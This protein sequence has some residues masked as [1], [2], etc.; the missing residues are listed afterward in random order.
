MGSAE[1]VS[2]GMEPPAEL[3]LMELFRARERG[4]VAMLLSLAKGEIA[5]TQC[6]PA[7]L[8]KVD[9][10]FDA[11]EAELEVPFISRGRRS[12]VE[13]AA[14]REA[15]RRYLEEAGSYLRELLDG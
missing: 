15:R 5:P 7:Y 10:A 3:V 14:V 9:R 11:R 8:Q 12:V 2:G 13:L 4:C 6:L 1:R